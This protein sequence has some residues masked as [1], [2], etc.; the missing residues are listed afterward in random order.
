ME[1]EKIIALFFQ[2]SEMALEQVRK[3]YGGLCAAVAG[4][5]LSD[6]RD[7]EECVTDTWLRM[8]RSIPSVPR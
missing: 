4:R 8:W 7:I 3:K 2:R 6:A 1:D 5:I